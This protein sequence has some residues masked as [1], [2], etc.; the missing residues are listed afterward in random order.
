[1]KTPGHDQLNAKL[2]K[3]DP[4]LAARHLLFLFVKIW[5]NKKSTDD[6]WKGATVKNPPRGLL[7]DHHRANLDSGR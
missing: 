5:M 4:D 2:L 7:Q 3:T 6:W 1:M